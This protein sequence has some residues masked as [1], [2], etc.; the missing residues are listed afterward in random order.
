MKGKAKSRALFALAALLLAAPRICPAAPAA[1]E[2]A[3]LFIAE[4]RVE[5]VHLLK[6]S[7]VEDAVYPWLGPHRTTAD[8]EAARAAVEKLYHDRGYQ[9]VSVVT[10]EQ[11]IAR[12]I[13]R[14]TV[15]EAPVGRLRVKGARYASPARIKAMAPSLAEGKVINFNEVPRDIVALNQSADR[16]VT[17]ALQAGATPGSVDVDLNVQDSP[18]VHGS[19]EL[20]NRHSAGTKPLRLNGSIS[21]NNLWQREDSAGFSFQIAPERIDDAKVFSGYYI[22][23]FSGVSWLSLM[24]QGTKQDSNASTLGGAAVAGRGEIAGLRALISL[25]SGKEYFHS[26]SL[27]F[28]YKHFDQR[29]TFGTGANTSLL[30]SP[31]TYVPIT[32]QYS[33]TW[34]KPGAVTDGNVSATFGTRGLG[35]GSEQFAVSRYHADAGF[36]YLRGDLSHTHDLP[37]GWV[38]FG[39]VQAQVADRPLVSS[40][41]F[42]GGGASTVRGYIE[43]ETIGDSGAFG[44]LELRTPS[45]HRWLGEPKGELR[46][47]AF[48]DAGGVTLIDPLPGQQGRFGLASYGFGVLFRLREHFSG[49]FDAAVPVY[50]QSDTKANHVRITFHTGLDF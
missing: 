19:L 2:A 44:T 36:V 10:P 3:G 8:I 32:G 27:G 4:Y 22:T 42:S 45:L 23:R 40:E 28:D 6:R 35:S 5:G 34:N 9:T 14:L 7:E 33:A 49:A 47:Y 13:V 18:P 1:P 31:V 48:G 17:P 12:G 21:D 20:N 24:A 26:L 16:K 29:L 25:P 37:K 46:F 41:Q 30:T 15:A 11:D 39:R 43:S 50:T 38:V